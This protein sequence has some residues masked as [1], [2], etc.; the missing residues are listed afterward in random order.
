MRP[1]REWFSIYE[2]LDSSV[3]VMAND[4][5]CN[6]VNISTVRIETHA[7]V[8][9]TLSNVGHIF[10]VKCHLVHLAPLNLMGASIQLKVEF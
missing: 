6:V 8:L 1:H 7:G 9:R 10:D 3:V 5:Q 2:P 4:A